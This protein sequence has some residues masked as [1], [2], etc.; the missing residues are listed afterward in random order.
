MSLYDQRVRIKFSNGDVFELPVSVIAD[1]RAR[2]YAEREGMSF[3]QSLAEDTI[4]LFES[5]HE[6]IVYWAKGE[7]DWQDVCDQVVLIDPAPDYNHAR[8]WG[9]TEFRLV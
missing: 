2:Y 4:P 8:H 6:E 9:S 5:D 7:M 1:A 3:E